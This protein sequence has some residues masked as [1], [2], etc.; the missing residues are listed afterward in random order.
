MSALKPIGRLVRLRMYRRPARNSCPCTYVSEIGCTM[1]I[2]PAS[3]TAAT[4]SGL[5]HGYIA[6]Q[7]S[8]T[9]TLAC[10]VKGVASESVAVVPESAADVDCVTASV[11][12]RSRALRPDEPPYR[13]TRN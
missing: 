5:L 2:A 10:R 6:P 13:R 3:D 4:S 1:P 9:A 11:A 7:M 12:F 8:G